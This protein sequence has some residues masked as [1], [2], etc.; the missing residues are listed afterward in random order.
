[1]HLL[2]LFGWIPI[3]FF[4]CGCMCVNEHL[5]LIKHADADVTCKPLSRRRRG[6]WILPRYVKPAFRFVTGGFSSC[7]YLTT[8]DNNE[9]RTN[10]H[11]NM[12]ILG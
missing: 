2:V 1:M 11:L 7:H 9:K 4:H 10:E 12:S 8:P 5:C 3:I 6:P